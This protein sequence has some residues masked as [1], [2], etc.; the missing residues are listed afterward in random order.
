[1]FKRKSYGGSY[2][3]S[4]KGSYKK[5]T[6]YKRTVR[7]A[8]MGRLSRKR[9]YNPRRKYYRHK[10]GRHYFR[11]RR[12]SKWYR[13]YVKK[14][15]KGA[16]IHTNRKATTVGRYKALDHQHFKFSQHVYD[17]YLSNLEATSGVRVV[18]CLLDLN[19]LFQSAAAVN[20]AT[21]LPD[22]GFFEYPLGTGGSSGQSTAGTALIGFEEY[23][24]RNTTSVVPQYQFLFPSSVTIEWTSRYMGNNVRLDE[25]IP[26]T[27]FSL[28]LGEAASGALSLVAGTTNGYV[29]TFG[30]TGEQQ[31]QYISEQPHA[32]V[33]TVNMGESQNTKM[34]M[35]RHITLKKFMR[36]HFPYMPPPG[37]TL[38]GSATRSYLHLL[39]GTNVTVPTALDS[40]YLYFGFCVPASAQFEG[41][42][43]LENQF[44]ITVWMT[45]FER[46]WVT[47][48]LK[49]P[50]PVPPLPPRLPT[51]EGGGVESKEEKKESKEDDDEF[52]SEDYEVFKQ[53]SGK[54][55]K[56]A[57]PATPPPPAASSSS[58][59]SSLSSL[60]GSL[61]PVPLRRAPAIL[62]SL[63]KS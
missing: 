20:R 31:I 9:R 23:L 22:T 59:S 3:G 40:C 21:M 56:L 61:S 54:M 8:P 39:A 57:V 63:V 60:A 49:A 53:L 43:N 18:G 1:M 29:P 7:A 35:K 42:L 33:K 55:S 30:S 47:E 50:K 19:N 5:T 38:S 52:T 62:G 2:K 28:P 14:P 45:A 10:S 17:T 37:Q 51:T 41:Y 26:V 25:H 13:V 46:T 24:R 32:R 12:G 4:R 58:S 27:F 15:R 36:P 44:K 34:Y 11:R 16:K 6:K 48:G